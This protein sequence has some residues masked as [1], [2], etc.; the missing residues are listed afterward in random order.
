MALLVE[1]KLLFEE[2]I[3][4]A[5]KIGEAAELEALQADQNATISENIANIIR[6]ENIH[7]LILPKEYGYPQLDWRTFVDMVST[8]GY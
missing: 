6:N 8:V 3:E 1:N 7:R 2:M 4:K 5:K